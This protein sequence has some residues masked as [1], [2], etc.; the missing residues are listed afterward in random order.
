M[1]PSRPWYLDASASASRG[2]IAIFLLPFLLVGLFLCWAMSLRTITDYARSSGWERVDCEIVSINLVEKPSE[3]NSTFSISA[4]F[5]YNYGGKSYTG[6]RYDFDQGSWS[7]GLES[8]RTAVAALSPGSRVTCWVNPKVPGESVLVRQ[9]RPQCFLGIAF[10]LPFIAAGSLSL[11]FMFH[12]V[13][14]RLFKRRRLDRVK[15]LVQSGDLPHWALE[16]FESN[17]SSTSIALSQDAR[18]TGFLGSGL[19]MLF[20]NGLVSV[21]LF[22]CADQWTGSERGNA[23]MLTLFLIPFVVVGM[24]IIRW[25]LQH[26]RLLFSEGWIV[27]MQ[28]VHGLAGGDVRVG[29]SLIQPGSMPRHVLTLKLAAC[30]SAWDYESN[31]TTRTPFRKKASRKSNG[32]GETEIATIPIPSG[33]CESLV[34]LPSIQSPHQHVQSHD[35]IGKW[36]AKGSLGVWWEAQLTFPD[37]TTERC[38][39]TKSERI[40]HGGS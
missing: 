33:S 31:D 6:C 15:A 36:V 37:G 4:S 14:R 13:L 27:T 8:M 7:F 38:D 5:R 22:V 1:T 2:C 25:W 23:W 12:P 34:S 10:S 32:S 30:A 9:L 21:F 26:V 17:N 35:W 24:F 29:W 18:L 39:L 28:P 20:W 3:T 19:F 11:I 16:A 40:S